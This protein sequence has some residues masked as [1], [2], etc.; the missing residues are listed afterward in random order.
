[1]RPMPLTLRIGF[2]VRLAPLPVSSLQVIIFNR[3][4]RLTSV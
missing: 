2:W 3:L 4:H 1:M